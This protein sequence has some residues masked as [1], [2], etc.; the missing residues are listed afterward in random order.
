MTYTVTNLGGPTPFQQPTW[1]DLIYLSRDTFLDLRADRFLTSVPHADGLVAGGAYGVTRT[2]TV[3]TDMATEAYYVFVV[4]DP[5]RYT[6]TGDLFEGANERNNDRAGAVPMVI[7]LPPP[8]DLVV[9]GILVPA[10]ARVGEPV[11][12]EWTVTNQSLSVPAAG[13]WTDSL[14]LSTDATWDITDRPLGRAAFTGTLIPGTSYTLT[15]DTTLP[16]ATPGQYRVV[17]RT[18]IFNQV[19]ESVNEVNNRMASADTLSVAVDELQIGV[20]LPTHLNPAQERLYRITVPADQTLRINL[21]AADEKSANE[22][23]VRHGAVPTSAAFDATYDGP[24]GSNLSALVSSTEPGAY[25]LL[26]RNFSAPAEGLDITLLAELLPLAITNVHTDTG[27]DSQHVTTTI[28]GAQFHPDAIVKV[29]R[30]GI[31]EYEPLDWK[32]VDSSTIIATFDFTDAPH[33]LYDLKVINPTGDEAVIPYRFL[34]ERAIEPEVTIGIGGPRMILAGDQATYSVALQNLANLDAPYTYFE[35]GVPQLNLNQ[36]VYGLPYLEFFTNVRGTPEGAAGTANAQVPWVHLE[37][38]TNTTGQLIASGY[39]FDEAA[40]GFA[41][42]SF[43]VITYPG[44]KELHDRNF[45]AFRKQMSLY[46][47]DLDPLLAEGEGGLDDWWEAV[48]DEAAAIDPSYGAILD[49]I[50]LVGMYKEN[51]SAPGKCQI[52][53]IPFRFH[54]VASATTMTRA[55]FVSHQSQQAIDL[56]QAILAS[57]TA[58]GPLLAL[59]A[60]EGTWVDLYLAALEDAG[61]LRPDGATPPIRTQQ[62]I[63]SLMATLASGILFGSAGTEI[64]SNA[65]LLGFFDQV[66]ELYGHDQNL[67]AEIEKWDPRESECYSGAVPIPV[68]PD[69]ADYNLGLTTPTHFEAF[70]I[71]VPWV[72]FEERGAGLPADFQISGPAQPVGGE[73]FAALNFSKYFQGE[74]VTGRLASLTGPQ[75]FDTQGWLPV[76]KALPYSIGFQNAEDASRCI[77][78]IRVVTQLDPDLDARSFQLGDIKIGD[79][80][81]DVPDGRSLFQGDYDFAATRGF[82]LRVS[83]GIDLYQEPAQATWMIQAI[84]PLTGEVLQDTSRG[85]LAPNDA[86]GTGAGFVS[87]TVEALPEAATGAKITAKARVLFDTQAPEDTQVLTQSVDGVAPTSHI[88]VGRIGTTA[89]FNVAWAKQRAFT[90]AQAARQVA[91]VTRPGDGGLGQVAA[92]QFSQ[93]HDFVRHAGPR[94]RRPT[95]PQ[96]RQVFRPDQVAVGEQAG[97]L[98]QVAQFAHIARKGISGESPEGRRGQVLAATARDALEQGTGQQ[99][100]V[101]QALAQGRQFDREHRNAVI[102]VGPKGAGRDHRRQVA[103]GGADQ[104]EVGLLRFVA[105]DPAIAASLEQ[106][107]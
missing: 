50:D 83:A 91:P 103:V 8:T 99:G 26:V 85:L 22:I 17:A 34:V 87:Y 43:N 86:L 23:F 44:L 56:R 101:F 46:F 58:P 54:V 12:F 60:D 7:E 25:Y 21:K 98:Q 18:D 94:P 95:G 81:I 80:T 5:A 14:F 105:T 68:L 51:R 39:L 37:S 65:D 69:F 47:P 3:P 20:P 107:Q 66:R 64:R 62:H 36:Y 9:T 32:V 28:R 55:E 93:R 106:A 35:L 33:G 75:T 41:G 2:L 48:K 97:A 31:A 6:T 16:P 96:G 104:P 13:T 70:R 76:A 71:Y 72:R 27:G 82:I 92:L 15:L 10:Q 1:E 19:Y 88:T 78:E 24:L 53:F 79:I 38:I 42:F 4:T 74:G 100:Q 59:A 102:Q 63:V 29:V 61:L 11:H 57:N 73:D 49:K 30:P 45:E 40:D 67:M 89:N 77:N 84:D 90:D 52:P